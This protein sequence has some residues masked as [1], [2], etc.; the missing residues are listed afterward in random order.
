MLLPRCKISII[1]LSGLEDS[2][3]RILFFLKKG[4]VCLFLPFHIEPDLWGYTDA[5]PGVWGSLSTGSAGPEDQAAP[6]SPGG[7]RIRDRWDQIQPAGTQT[8]RQCT[9]VS[10]ELTVKR[11][12]KHQIQFAHECINILWNVLW[13][14]L[15]LRYQNCMRWMRQVYSGV[16]Y[17]SP[18]H[19][20]GP[21]QL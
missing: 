15:L 18:A 8:K 2:K 4:L 9:E 1:V 11:S 20:F 12:A 19:C 7:A 14:V 17:C 5:W 16:S 3:S 21:T 13:K 6:A 10:G